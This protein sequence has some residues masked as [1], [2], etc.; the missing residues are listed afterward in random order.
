MEVDSSS[1]QSKSR[2]LITMVSMARS[3][4]ALNDGDVRGLGVL[5]FRDFG[6]IEQREKK[7]S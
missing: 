5:G 6:E 7:A 3:G 4:D 2:P 1:R